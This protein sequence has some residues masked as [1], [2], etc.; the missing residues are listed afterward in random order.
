MNDS[1]TTTRQEDFKQGIG[2]SDRVTQKH[3]ERNI[4][5]RKQKR[6][7]AMARLRNTGQVKQDQFKQY[8]SQLNLPSLLSRQDAKQLNIL[9]QCLSCATDGQV[10]E[11]LPQLIM[12][13]SVQKSSPVISFLVQLLCEA[14]IE[15]GTMA[16]SCLVNISGSKL[17]EDY[18]PL[19]A[20][21]LIE[22]H[23]LD[24]AISH[25]QQDSCIAKDC[26]YI[27]A[28]LIGLCDAS[29]DVVLCSTLFKNTHQRSDWSSPFLLE[30]RRGR[31]DYEKLIFAICSNSFEMG[32]TLPDLNYCVVVLQ[33]IISYLS[34]NWGA[35]VR[36]SSAEPDLILASA[37]SSLSEFAQ[38]CN[39]NNEEHAKT[40]ALV[41]GDAHRRG[42]GFTFLVQ[43]CKRLCILNQFRLS[44]FFIKAGKFN[45]PDHALQSLMYDSGCAQLMI[46]YLEHMDSRLQRQGLIWIG[47]FVSDSFHF[48]K[49]IMEM[50]AFSKVIRILRRPS[51]NQIRNGAVYC[52]LQA[53]TICLN[54]YK[55]ATYRNQANNYIARL[56]QHYKLVQITC[57]YV[58]VRGEPWLTIDILEIW[59][60]LLMWDRSFATREIEL[61]GGLDSV[62]QL[63]GSPSEE[64]FKL[65]ER[66]LFF[67]EDSNTMEMDMNE[68]GEEEK[69]IAQSM[70]KKFYF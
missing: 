1:T 5:I 43:L 20:Q 57:M 22:A 46:D 48:M 25:I 31:P 39:I 33:Y 67:M 18:Q 28:N 47:N 21:L 29:R 24:A 15:V 9:N 27:V 26:W 41:V 34:A 59:I 36:E 70:Q 8:Y 66:I 50:D 61:Y 37:I 23:F 63:L 55:D 16:S 35:N 42:C 44:H 30:M 17:E 45:T 40:F 7:R 62:H 56:V 60:S 68:D 4:S 2:S 32:N 52:L 49:V 64:I 3:V 6:D 51:N 38:K 54:A 10:N 69:P 53:S 13:D 12:Y 19:L 11:Y 58:D 14:N 65:S